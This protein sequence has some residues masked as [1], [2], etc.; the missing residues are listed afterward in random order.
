MNARCIRISLRETEAIEGHESDRFGS[1][2]VIRLVIDGATVTFHEYI[3]V[4]D[5]QYNIILFG[6]CDYGN[7]RQM[8][9]WR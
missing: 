3:L 1:F 8:N 9:A 7:L 2:L 5:S 6:N 4:R